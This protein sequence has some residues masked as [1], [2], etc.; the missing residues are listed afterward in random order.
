MKSLIYDLWARLFARPAWRKLHSF[1]LNLALRGLGVGNCGSDALSG[2]RWLISHFLS[3]RLKGV[4]EPVFLDVG[5]NEGQYARQL[6]NAFP[7]ARITCFEPGPRTFARLEKVA[8]ELRLETVPLAVGA[9]LGE[10]VLYDYAGT[11]NASQHASL[12]PGV[13]EQQHGGVVEGTPVRITTL[14]EF[15]REHSLACIDFLK[16]DVEGNE[17]ACLEGARGLLARGAIRAIQFEFNSMNLLARVTMSQFYA[18]LAGFDLYRLLPHGLLR[19]NRADSVQSNIF[20]FQN[21][22]ALP[23]SSHR[24]AQ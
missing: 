5:A 9:D 11:G 12:V 2:E 13:I 8:A 3:L 10:T 23:S 24:P 7:A 18:L 20:A 22:V 19:L 14:D 1:M 4:S 17:L 16:I 6:R 21:I 15:C